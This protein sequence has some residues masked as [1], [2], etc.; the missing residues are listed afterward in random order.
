[1]PQSQSRRAGIPMSLNTDDE[2]VNRSNPTLRSSGVCNPGRGSW[3]L[4]SAFVVMEAWGFSH[5]EGK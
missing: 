4:Q 3:D 2:G 5:T 1:M